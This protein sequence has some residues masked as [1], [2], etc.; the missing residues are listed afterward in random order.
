MGPVELA[1]KATTYPLVNLALWPM[2]MLL[3]SG[4]VHLPAPSKMTGAPKTV[5][6]LPPDRMVVVVADVNFTATLPAAIAFAAAAEVMLSLL[7]PDPLVI[8]V[9]PAIS[10][11]LLTCRVTA[12][13]EGTL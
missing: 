9:D 2:V 12:R 4:S 5:A 11:M 7:L 13:A 6:L 3:L 8:A 1:G 10:N